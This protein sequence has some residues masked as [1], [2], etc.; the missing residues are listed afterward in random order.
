[1]PQICHN[2]GMISAFLCVYLH[3][4]LLKSFGKEAQNGTSTN[5]DTG[6]QCS[7]THSGNS[8][9]TKQ[10]D[11]NHHGLRQLVIRHIDMT[12]LFSSAKRAR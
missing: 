3:V 5:S 12:G 4:H 10:T 11:T 8:T 9:K 1:M 7:S 6:P 2:C